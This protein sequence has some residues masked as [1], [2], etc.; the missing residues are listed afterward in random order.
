MLTCIII[1]LYANIYY[2]NRVTATG[3]VLETMNSDHC[4]Y[5]NV[6]TSCG[7]MLHLLQPHPPMSPEAIQ[8]SDDQQVQLVKSLEQWWRC[9]HDSKAHAA[10]S[11]VLCPLCKD[12]PHL[13]DHLLLCS[14]QP[15]VLSEHTKLLM[16]SIESAKSCDVKSPGNKV[17]PGSHDPQPSGV[18]IYN[19]ITCDW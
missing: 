14:G 12:Q 3:A 5:L 16:N 6:T 9:E 17:D 4:Y 2:Y 8:Q 10:T 13:L 1:T 7:V 11:G 15:V 19:I 18:I